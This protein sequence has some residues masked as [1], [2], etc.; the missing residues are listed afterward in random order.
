MTFSAVRA[1]SIEIYMVS[2]YSISVEIRYVNVYYFIRKIQSIVYTAAFGTADM[3]MLAD[4]AV[5]AG[6]RTADFQFMDNSLPR[7]QI[8]ISVDCPEAYSGYSFAY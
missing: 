5:K 1:D 6:R 2:F 3:I 4:I 8:K 7:E